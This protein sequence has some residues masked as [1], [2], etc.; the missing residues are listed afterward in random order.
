MQILEQ[1]TEA[2]GG[3]ARIPSPH[4]RRRRLLIPLIVVLACASG[5]KR[6]PSGSDVP[7]LTV[8][9][10]VDQLRGD[11]LETY[12]PLFRHGLKRL[13][14]EGRWYSNAMI[15]HG[16]TETAAGHATVA[17]GVR[18]RVHG[19]ID[20]WFYD[21]ATARVQYVCANNDQTCGTDYLMAPTI[22]D[23]LKESSRVSRVVALAQ[24][25]RS[26]ML[27]G[28]R[29][30]DLVAW[31]QPSPVG[32][33]GRQNG[34][35]GVPQWLN[36]FYVQVAGHDRINY[37]WE[38]PRL[39]ERFAS[40][41]D[42]GADELDPGHGIVFP[43]HLPET[44]VGEDRY[45]GWFA[46]PD[47]DRALQETAAHVVRRMELGRGEAPD[48]L[49][50]SFG[51]FDSIGHAFGPES[52]ERVA[53]FVEI[54]RQLGDLLEAL[55]TSVGRRLLVALTSDHG[56]APTP[57]QA[58]A[59]G[60]ASARVSPES[61]AAVA[62]AALAGR[63][64]GSAHVAAVL[65]PFITLTSIPEAERRAAAATVATALR[66]HPAVHAA[67]PVSALKSEHDPLARL[68]YESAHPT[69]AGDVA[70]VL[71]PYHA[72]RTKWRG[73]KGAEHGTP[74]PYDRHVPILMWGDGVEPGRVDTEVTLVDLTRTLG[75]RLGLEPVRGGGKP[76][77]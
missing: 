27:L 6:S 76:L 18:P 41:R 71:E 21:R 75:D 26:A 37:L 20:K 10:I 29:R 11:E 52:L 13:L 73:E 54:D 30:A 8:L 2:P 70:V 66:N 50:V 43:H 68:M 64:G 60:H 34:V 47:A 59:L 69:R 19:I 15:D 9:I 12:R 72:M 56:V 32:M 24:K 16:R 40:R 49:L 74:W 44:A 5:C 14:D 77:P 3:L 23:R 39:P 36:R 57:H 65:G 17:T 1:W 31:A 4:N 58:R 53:S 22:G 67:W 38:L 48:L 42:A 33:L 7:R 63:Y 62:D 45:W 61:L 25:P 28:G 35:Q 51:A 55:R 46:S